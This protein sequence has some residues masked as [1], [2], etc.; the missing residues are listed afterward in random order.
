MI[1]FTPLPIIFNAA[2]TPILPASKALTNFSLAEGVISSLVYFLTSSIAFLV[3]FDVTLSLA[4][5]NKP[6]A[7]STALPP[8][9]LA[10]FTTL[11][12]IEGSASAFF[13]I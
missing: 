12:I 4:L 10:P 13:S 1:L 9:S 3:S 7:P 8:N 2:F 5:P 6:L 11:D